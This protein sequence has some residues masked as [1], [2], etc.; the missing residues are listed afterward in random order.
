MDWLLPADQGI[1]YGLVALVTVLVTALAV[2]IHHLGLD[3]LARRLGGRR[4][5]RHRFVMAGVILAL[6]GLHVVEIAC[7]GAAYWGLDQIPDMGFVENRLNLGH[8]HGGPNMAHL[9][10]AI[11]FSAMA[12]ST[13][14]FG[15]VAPTGAM[16][17]LAATEAIAG[18]ILI[19]WSA[20]FTYLEMSRMW[21][22]PRE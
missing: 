5:R 12:Y 6:L 8:V 13:V 20:S 10:D 1:E 16:R 17:I 9:F 7:Y 4:H 14:S 18:L 22:A 21:T 15:D 3:A 2:V 19:A 11:Y